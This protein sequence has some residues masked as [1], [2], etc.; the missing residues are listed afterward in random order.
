MRDH[1]HA[2]E[3]F[4]TLA[5]QSA[6]GTNT[7]EDREALKAEGT[8][9]MTEITRIANQTKFGGKTVFVG[10]TAGSICNTGEAQLTLLESFLYKLALR[11]K[12]PL[13][14]QTSDSLQF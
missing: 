13:T 1:Q 11:M 8:S 4:S 2:S 14:F 3:G 12:S 6:N 10:A 7:K 5:V 9:L